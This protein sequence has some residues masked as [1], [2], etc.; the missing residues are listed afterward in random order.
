MGNT[1]TNMPNRLSMTASIPRQTQGKSFGEKINDGATAVAANVAQGTALIGGSIG[2]SSVISAAISSV[3]SLSHASATQ[4]ATAGVLNS[5]LSA[6]NN[7]TNPANLLAGINSTGVGTTDIAEMSRQN[8]QML[9]V[10]MA[11]QRENT[12]F[13]SISNVLKTKHDTAKNSISNIR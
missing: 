1:I 9:Q 6:T 7:Q 3:N 8:A 5:P 13:S 12:M 11:M 4:Y 2:G 10:Q